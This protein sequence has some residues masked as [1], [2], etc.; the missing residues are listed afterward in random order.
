MAQ[1]T[2]QLIWDALISGR[3]E[4]GDAISLR[5]DALYNFACTY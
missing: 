4:Q 2:F 1:V 5:F 3:T